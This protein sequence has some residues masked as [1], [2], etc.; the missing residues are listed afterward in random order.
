LCFT[1]Y[2]WASESS[3]FD[4]KFIYICSLEH[5]ISINEKKTQTIDF[6]LEATNQRRAISFSGWE[7]GKREINK[8]RQNK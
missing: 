7:L 2:G 5:Y 6:E 8:T 4:L 1:V 3:D